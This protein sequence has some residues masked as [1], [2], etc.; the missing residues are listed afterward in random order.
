[1]P[2]PNFETLYKLED[3]LEEAVV[4]V[5]SGED[6]PPAIRSQDASDAATPRVVVDVQV[7]P[8]DH[9]Y[10]HLESD[11]M[12]SQWRGTL[13]VSVI[14]QRGDDDQRPYH[15]TWVARVRMA[16]QDLPSIESELEY[17]TLPFLL[18]NGTTRGVSPEQDEDNTTVQFA[19]TLA[20]DPDSW[21][22]TE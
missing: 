11:I 22:T 13:S 10:Q 15:S 1:M 21:P 8:A 17:H 2:A 16:M 14:S 6:L 12:I 20:V 3:A 19:F 9:Q 7:G 5:L 4:A 18:E